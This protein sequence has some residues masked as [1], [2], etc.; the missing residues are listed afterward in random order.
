MRKLAIAAFS[1]GAGVFAAVYIF[2]GVGLFYF[3]GICVLLGFLGFLLR[4]KKRTAVIL[5]CFSA[6]VGLLWSRG[7][8]MIFLSKAYALR[9]TEGSFT[10]ELSDYPEET[11]YGMKCEVK[12]DTGDILPVKAMLYSYTD[13]LLEL[14]PGDRIAFEGEILPADNIAGEETSSFTSKGYFLRIYSDRI[15]EVRKAESLPLRYFPRLISKKTGEIID[16]IYPESSQGLMRAL[17]TGNTDFLRKNA[18]FT[19][20]LKTSGVYH[21][22]AVSGMHVAF[23]V[24]MMNAFIRRRRAAGIVAI[25]VIIIFMAVVGFTPSVTRAGIMQLI[26]IAASLFM[27]EPDPITSLGVAL[28]VILVLNPYSAMSAGLQLSFGATLGILLFAGR[29]THAVFEKVRPNKR[30]KSRFAKGIFAAAV[31]SFSVSLSA[32]VFTVPLSALYFGYV[33]IIAPATNLLI[34]PVV[35]FIFCTDVIS[36]IAGAVFLK[37][38]VIAAMAAYLPAAYLRFVVRILGGAFF[39]ALYT[40][41]IYNVLWLV[42][43]Y[44]MLG[45]AVVFKARLRQ[46]LLPAS[47]AAVS[48]C[49]MLLAGVFINSD[50]GFTTSV[51]DVEQ[52][53]C[54]IITSGSFTAV[55]DCGSIGGES[56]GGEAVSFLKSHGRDTIDV[57]IL[58]HYHDDHVNGVE[59]LCAGVNVSAIIAPEPAEED[60]E[61]VSMI[62]SALGGE[63]LYAGS[64]MTVQLGDMTASLYP[65]KGGESENER[66]LAVVFT[67]NDYDVLI[68]GDMPAGAERQLVYSEELPDTEL[69]IVGHHGSKYSTCTELLETVSPEKAVISVGRNSYGHP[70]EETLSRL[71]SMGVEVY[72]TDMSGNVI[73]DGIIRAGE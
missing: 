49:V 33:S 69:M 2:S 38:G 20:T 8:D 18:E 65:P 62:E 17:L 57:L 52:G 27:R 39:S 1:F 51:L 72:R 64:D 23:F 29:M 48:L 32:M 21:I 60:T 55:I 73:I 50:T 10:A 4:D 3:A 46:M 36:V 24:G 25:P 35:N 11:Y 37:A 66:C 59:E 19:S 67:E 41:N 47:F 26:I 54:V 56:A 45:A 14:E 13:E 70:A 9:N 16:S 58:T 5:I 12:L 22:A 7:Y 44:L 53:Q 42:Y 34:L 71:K 43:V 63:I 28:A 61:A 68:T 31:K 30:F 40:E 15:T 6:A